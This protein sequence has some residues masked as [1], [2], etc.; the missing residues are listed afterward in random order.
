MPEAGEMADAPAIVVADDIVDV[1]AVASELAGSWRAAVRS[2][3]ELP[4]GP[5][6]VGLLAGPGTDV[7]AAVMD[8]LPDLRVIVVTSMG[9]DHVDTDAARSRGVTV[10]GVE[11]YCVDEVAE[12][13]VALVLDLLR[14]VTW[15]DNSVRAGHWD[16]A[17]VGRPVRGAALGL[18]GLGRI[19]AAVAWRGRGLGMAVAAFDPFAT[20]AAGTGTAMRGSAAA[21]AAEPG[22]VRMVG[23]LEELV[24]ASDVVSLHVPL[25]PE[26]KGL[27]DRDLLGHFREGSYLVNVSRGEVVT[28][29]ALGEALRGGRLAGAALDVLVHEPP[30]GDDPVL[31]FPHTVVT[32]HAAWYSPLAID[33]LSRSAGRALARA[34]AD[35]EAV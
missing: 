26:T 6:I 4:S 15:L 27:V 8:R 1:D 23:S 28:E 24:S 16:Y 34:L 30:P 14:G 25:T 10:A 18:V 19:G 5:G 22:D 35:V 33:R 13:T 17:S 32:P 31:A 2:E 3:K 12:H 21:S 11:P 20:A 7:S 9:W 29:P